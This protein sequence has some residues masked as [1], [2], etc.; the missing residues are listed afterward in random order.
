MQRFVTTG[1]ARGAIA[2]ALLALLA[3]PVAAYDWFQFNGNAGHSGGNI[4]ETAI[5]VNNVGTLQQLF[6]VTLPGNADGAPAYLSNVSTSGGAKDLVFL[7]T[8]DGHIL[9]LDARTGGTV[10][11]KQFG[12]GACVINVVPP[13][14]G[15]PHTPCFTTSSPAVDPN[16][17]FVYTYGLDGKAHKLAVG[18]GDESTTNGWPQVATL[19]PWQEKGSS[20]LAIVTAKSGA[21]YLYV[22]NAGYP[23]DSGDYQGHITAINLTTGAQ[24]VFNGTCSNQTVHFVQSPGTPDCPKL[25]TAI[26]ARPGVVYSGETDRVYLST[27]NGDFTPPQHYY[28]D[29]VFALNPDGSGNGAGDPLDVYTP[30]DEQYLD[31]KDLDLGSTAPAIFPPI[32]NGTVPH[33][34]AQAGKDGKIRLLNLDSLGAARTPD[35]KGGEI[36]AIID[37]PQNVGGTFWP[38]VNTQPAV[39]TNPVDS[40]VWLFVTN[41]NGISGLQLAVDSAGNPA[42]VP[43]WKVISTGAQTAQSSPLVANGV[44]YYASGGNLR[45]FNATTGAQLWQN[46]QIGGIHW[47][48]PVVVNGVLYLSDFNNR[49]TAWTLPA[50][51]VALAPNTAPTTGGTTITASGNGFVSGTT[52]T[53]DSVQATNVV[54]GGTQMTFTAPPHAAGNASV[55]IRAPNGQS[56]T[57]GLLYQG[58]V[59]APTA[60]APFPTIP[61]LAIPSATSAPLPTISPPHPATAPASLATPLPSFRSG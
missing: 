29:S 55:V 53:V 27:G 3:G 34:A 19:K 43:Q 59:A 16:R 28:G 33:F 41:G 5:G 4:H 54:T 51:G 12:P 22:A 25:E 60:T 35:R 47:S 15:D 39:W 7:T 18:T 30:A 17:Q 50:T 46:T 9:A 58:G 38:G 32:A 56:T 44:V 1:F 61:P 37:V 20:A 14:T 8:M 31:D 45:A 52:V 40:H 6:Q 42:L 26:W 10:W 57:V 23:G 21:S 24:R 49:L 13:A 2:L 36:G 48:S 11:S